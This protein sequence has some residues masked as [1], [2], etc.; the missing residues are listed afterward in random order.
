MNFSVVIPFRPK[1]ESND[2]NNECMLL[3]KTVSSLLR[4]TYKHIKIFIVYTDF[5]TINLSDSRINF[6]EFIYGYQKFEEIQKGEELLRQFGTKQW[7]VRNWDKGR[8]L[9]YGSYIAMQSDCDY[10]MAMDADDLLSK[11]FFDILVNSANGHLVPGWYMNAG[12]MMKQGGRFL[13]KI[14]KGFKDFNGSSH[15]L[16]KDL[17][18]IPDFSSTNW[19]DFN[20]FTDHGWIFHRIREEY[21]KELLPL[22]DLTLIYIVHNSNISGVRKEYSI[23]IRKL[24]K[25]LI[26]SRPITNQIKDE[27][28]L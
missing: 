17:V 26:L 27:F 9:T 14:N 3:Q 12:Y 2:W 1:A 10:I 5:P 18:K 16:R 19:L 20:L 28:N 13:V 22:N 7:L 23:N 15:V 24:I 11:Y 6:I 4:Q 25:R 21:G 8:R